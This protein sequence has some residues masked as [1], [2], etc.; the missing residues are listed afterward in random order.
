MAGGAD[1]AVI[2]G[3]RQASHGYGGYSVF[4]PEPAPAVG[5]AS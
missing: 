5:V 1:D 2:A 3:E 4:G